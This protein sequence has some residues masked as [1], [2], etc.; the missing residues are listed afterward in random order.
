MSSLGTHSFLDRMDMTKRL[1]DALLPFLQEHGIEHFFFGSPVLLKGA[2]TIQAKLK[3]L[4]VKKFPAALMIKY[5]PDFILSYA[6][7][8]KGPFLLD[9]KASVTPVFKDRQIE[10]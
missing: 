1:D 10:V 3:Q 8:S 9:T 6:F 7:D 2:S 4:A 5:S